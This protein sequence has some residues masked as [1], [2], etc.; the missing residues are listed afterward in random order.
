MINIGTMHY[1][2]GSIPIDILDSVSYTF[3]HKK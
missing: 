3:P 2:L 1:F